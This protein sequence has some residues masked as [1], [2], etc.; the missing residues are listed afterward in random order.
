MFLVADESHTVILN[1]LFDKLKL[2]LFQGALA[3]VVQQSV[4]T[5][6]RHVR[7]CAS[8]NEFAEHLSVALFGCHVD[9]SFTSPIF[10]IQVRLSI[11]KQQL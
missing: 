6:I 4:A 3:Q 8:T 2:A 10:A 9:W 11:L 5:L 7:V 1:E